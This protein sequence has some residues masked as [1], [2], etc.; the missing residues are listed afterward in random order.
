MRKRTT[1]CLTVAV[2]LGGAGIRWSGDLQKRLEAFEKGDYPAALREW[3]PVAE[4]GNYRAQ[5][6]L[7]A[8]YDKGT[9][10]IQDYNTAVK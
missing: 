2:L 1:L 7:G 8:M 9:G 10:V 5:N 3:T 6:A 4:Q